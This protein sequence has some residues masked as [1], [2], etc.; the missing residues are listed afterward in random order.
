MTSVDGVGVLEKAKE[1]TIIK[2]PRI[3]RCRPQFVYFIYYYHLEY[4]VVVV[5]TEGLVG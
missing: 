4:V 1:I 3:R 2:M 5:I